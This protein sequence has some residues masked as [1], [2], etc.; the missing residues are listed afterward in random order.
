MTRPLAAFAG[1]V[2]AVIPRI[3]NAAP[4][5]DTA[6]P[7]DDP[8]PSSPPPVVDVVREDTSERHQ[9]DRT[10]L[11]A[12]DARVPQPLSVVAMASTSY[13]DVGSSPFRVAG[14]VVPTKYAAFAGNTAQPGVMTSL[15][16]EL[17]LLPRVSVV[18]L[19]QLEVAGET[20]HPNGG[21]VAGLRVLLTPT[22]WGRFHVVASGGYLRESWAGPVF[23]DDKN[24]WTAGNPDGDNGMWFQAAV[25]GDIGRLRM[26]GNLHAEHVF[27][28]GRDPLDVM[29]D[30]GATY[31]IAG[32]FRAGLEW[33]GQDLEE[34]FSPGAEGGARMFIGP[35]ASYQLLR[36]R[37]SIVA[38]PALGFSQATGEAPSFTGR[39]ALAYGF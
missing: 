16:A 13:T 22:S 18:A 30:L 32:G 3:A 39:L 34:T 10:W 1:L 5:F 12:D 17:G 21:G 31:R 26:V 2:I 15:G 25:S 36:E 28:A 38:G 33:V 14:V 8:A 23:D 4:G 29:V 6:S 37:L 19:G 9:I 35:I 7:P 20:S 27:S 11:Y 24:Q